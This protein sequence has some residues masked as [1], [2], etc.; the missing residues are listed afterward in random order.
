MKYLKIILLAFALFGVGCA[1]EPNVKLPP[2]TVSPIFVKPTIARIVIIDDNQGVVGIAFV[3]EDTII[4]TKDEIKYTT[5]DGQRVTVHGRFS[6]VIHHDLK[7][8]APNTDVGKMD[9]Y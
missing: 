2:I 7:P 1:S 3:R 6:Y 5:I 4:W 8:E 9:K